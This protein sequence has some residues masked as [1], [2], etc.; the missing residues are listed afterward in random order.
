MWIGKEK[1]SLSRVDTTLNVSEVCRS[2][3]QFVKLVVSVGSSGGSSL[4]VSTQNAFTVMMCSQRARAACQPSLPQ[5]ISERTKKD[6]L[7][8]DIV[9]ML[10]QK[11]LKFSSGQIDSGKSYITT[12]TSA[13][14]YIYQ[15]HRTLAS[16]GCHVPDVFKPF[17][18]YNCP[19][20]SKHR[21]RERGSLNADKLSVF[22]ASLNEALLLSWLNTPKWASMREATEKFASALDSYVVYLRSQNK[23][24]KVH[25][26]SQAISI[27]DKTSVELLPANRSPSK[28]LTKLNDAISETGLAL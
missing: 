5:L 27:A 23:K 11:G 7:F 4:T 13:L 2:I 26:C 22:A 21:K 12:L 17:N 8:N 24:M 6:R 1:S 28:R 25:R 10:D 9:K 20:L 15:H 3:G 18:G 19:E 14:W 16:R